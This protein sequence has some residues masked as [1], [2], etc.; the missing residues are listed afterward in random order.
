MSNDIIDLLAETPADLADLR[1]RRPE[2]VENAQR[3]FAALFEPTNPTLIEALP[4]STRY[5]VAAFVAGIS[6]A[7]RAAEFYADLL[8]DEDES[9]VAVVEDAVRAGVSAGP[10]AGGDFVTFGDNALAVAFDFAH[11]LTFHPKDA[12]PAAIGHL[13]EVGYNETAI[14]SLGQLIAFVAFQLRV[15]HGVRVLAGGGGVPEGVDRRAG[16]ADPG[17]APAAATLQPEVVAPEK[18]VA[19]PLGWKPWVAPLEKGELTER[20]DRVFV[21]ACFLQVPDRRGGG[22]L[23]VEGEQVGEVERRGKRPLAESHEVPARVGSGRLACA[24]GVI[25]H[26]DQ[27]LVLV[28]KQIGVERRGA[29][30]AGNTGDERGD[31]VAGGNR[32]RLNQRVV[33]RLEQRLKAALGVL[34]RLGTAAAQLGEL[35]RGLCEGV[36]NVG[37]V[38]QQTLLTV[39][40]GTRCRGWR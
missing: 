20:D 7:Q 18:F 25:D 12:S 28:R 35:R 16:V 24:H 10:Y 3:S 30:R 37:A 11:L 14:V 8:A 23:R 31:G 15:V 21:V 26:G 4:V 40:P 5:A 33:G 2:A 19:H 9:L 13:Q 38:R 29:L 22:I 27:R 1:R 32:Q 6:G 34:H 39:G 17:W 36:D